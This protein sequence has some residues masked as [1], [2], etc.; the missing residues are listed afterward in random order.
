M[1]SG[2][3]DEIEGNEVVS[4]YD[5]IFGF[6][7]RRTQKRHE[8]EDKTQETIFRFL[9]WRE[10]REVRDR[11]RTLFQIAQ[12]LLIDRSRASQSRPSMDSALEED[13]AVTQIS[14][15][16]TV[17]ANERLAILRAAVDSMP[18]RVR[19]IFIM[20]RTHGMRHR[21]IAEA[22]GISKSTVEKHMIRALAICRSACESGHSAK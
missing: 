17:E 22:L 10:G 3:N 12:N 14:P 5:S 6:L 19:E 13:S 20:N 7:L 9:R 1:H 15:T 8:A 21:E 4:H 2:S 16:R 11:K 18:P